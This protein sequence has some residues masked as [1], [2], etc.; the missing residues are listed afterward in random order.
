MFCL[1]RPYTDVEYFKNK[2]R[3]NFY[4]P[5]NLKARW[6]QTAHPITFFFVLK[7]TSLKK[8]M[9]FGR[10]RKVQNTGSA[11]N[12]LETVKNILTEEKSKKGL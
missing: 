3:K 4:T 1:D 7:V 10:S 12:A 11:F 5:Q 8:K 6:L 9:Y 2:N